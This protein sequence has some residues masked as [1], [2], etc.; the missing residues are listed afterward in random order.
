MWTYTP[1]TVDVSRI[2]TEQLHRETIEE[3]N[4]EML[5]F[6]M[7]AWG[8]SC[9]VFLGEVN[10]A[11]SNKQVWH[12]MFILTPKM[13]NLLCFKVDC[14]G[15]GGT[16]VLHVFSV[17]KQEWEHKLQS[18]QMWISVGSSLLCSVRMEKVINC[19]K[20]SPDA[21]ARLICFPWAGGGSIHYA[22]WGNVLSSSIEGSMLHLALFVYGWV[23]VYSSL[24]LQF[25]RCSQ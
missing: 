15:G 8:I 16:T 9:T 10:G 18:Q 4:Q 5:H 23:S 24:H 1:H 6:S 12:N 2:H 20:R 3:N 11:V 25:I 17:V 13:L 14:L 21:V 7:S 22:R 19:F